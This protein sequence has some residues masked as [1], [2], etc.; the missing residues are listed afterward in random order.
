MIV[1]IDIGN[2]DSD[3]QRWN[4]GDKLKKVIFELLSGGW[5]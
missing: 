5:E 1:T 4:F 3:L 2:T